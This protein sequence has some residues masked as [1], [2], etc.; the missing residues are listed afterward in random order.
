MT[1]EGGTK[2]GGFLGSRQ[3]CYCRST[4]RILSLIRMVT[5][6]LGNC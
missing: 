1:M 2:S 5:D 6:K 3:I 4:D